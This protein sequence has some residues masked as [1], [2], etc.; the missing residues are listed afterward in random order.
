[1]HTTVLRA[2]LVLPVIQPPLENGMVVFA[3]G[4]IQQVGRWQ[5]SQV[6]AGCR[7]LDLGEA[8]LLPGLVNAHCH[9]DYTDLAGCLPSPASFTDW[10]HGIIAAK[11]AWS[12][13][14]F[15]TSWLHGAGMLLQHGVTTCLN[16][17]TRPDQV[18]QLAQATPL[19]IYSFLELIGFQPESRPE[20]IL[21]AAL[22]WLSQTSLPR[23]TPGWAPHAP[24]TTTAA[25]LHLLGQAARQ[26]QILLTMHVAES[27]DEFDL[28]THRRGPLFDW[29]KDRRDMSD[30]G[31]HTPTAYLEQCGLLS[32][33]LLAVHV[34]Y[35]GE[36]DA[37]RLGR[38]RVNVVH[39]PRSH[40][41]FRHDSFPLE[42]LAAA[43]V[44]ICL[45]TDS[46]ASTAS[47]PPANT[48]LDLFAEMGAMAASQ[49][50][51]PPREILKMATV[52][53]A[54]ALGLE[55]QV[56]VIKP[57]AWADFTVIPYAGP[58]N[59]A[60]EAVIHFSG[61]VRGTMIGGEWVVD[62]KSHLGNL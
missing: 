32:D 7:I 50:G 46:L 17:D 4:Q 19:R 47:R 29:L 44:N 61:P 35:L 57:Q 25:L 31:S 54:R 27:R 42:E 28:I 3:D 53:G 56:G 34:N 41:Y 49:P 10:I 26:N 13:S 59:T 11:K 33:R 24:H 16:I 22:D 45:G 2:R 58:T 30:C 8:I 62:P 9:L 12:D 38:H 18:N 55:G 37:C 21:R 23:G 51:L 5:V 48:E 43:E 15:K 39:C 60:S 20:N 52:N 14:N 40:A 6:P 1:M 36:G